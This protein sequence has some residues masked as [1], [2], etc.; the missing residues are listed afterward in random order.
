MTCKS[1][2]T[3]PTNDDSVSVLWNVE[4]LGWTDKVQEQIIEYAKHHKDAFINVL[5]KLTS[6]L[7]T[8]DTKSNNLDI[9]KNIVKILKFIQLL[10]HPEEYVVGLSAL[11]KK[12]KTNDH[13]NSEQFLMLAYKVKE[14]MELP[15]FN[16]IDQIYKEK[17]ENLKNEFPLSVRDLIWNSNN[18]TIK[19]V[20]HD[21]YMYITYEGHN[22]GV[23][24]WAPRDSLAG[25]Y[26]KITTDDDAKTFKLFGYDYKRYL[27]GENMSCYEHVYTCSTPDEFA[28]GTH[29][30]LR[31]VNGKFEIIYG[32]SHLYAGDYQLYGKRYV[33]REKDHAFKMWEIK[34]IY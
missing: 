22:F 20:H 34:C 21:D 16:Q 19:N 13:L 24:N 6:K 17:F 26:W 8:V 3:K 4:T 27:D 23:F 25:I 32:D 1:S 10:P 29:W 11:Y 9:G 15:I 2:Y 5:E 7:Y 30:Q 33:Y 31:P 28:K 14:V 18:C 12:M